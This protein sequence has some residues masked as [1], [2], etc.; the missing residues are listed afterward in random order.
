MG[1]NPHMAIFALLLGLS[2][3]QRGE[4]KP[5]EIPVRPELFRPSVR[6]VTLS[7]ITFRA[8][9]ESS[10]PGSEGYVLFPVP[11]DYSGQRV[12]SMRV[13][14]DPPAALKSWRWE[15]RPD[16]LNYLVRTDIAPT[17]GPVEIKISL[18]VLA[19][20]EGVIRTQHKDFA[21]WMEQSA[22]V[23][24]KDPEILA[25]AKTLQEPSQNRT[26]FAGRVAKWVAANKV[27]QD[28]MPGVSDAKSA[29]A[30]GGDSLGR[31]NL[32]AAVLRSVGIPARTIAMVP[33]WA[34]RIE[35]ENWL[36]E[37]W[38]EEGDWD[39]VDPNVGLKEP[40]RD[41][42]IVLAISSIADENR[43]PNDSHSFRPD[44]P[45]LTTPEVSPN[46][47]WS[48]PKTAR[49]LTSIRVVYGFPGPGGPRLLL[50]GYHLYQR[51]TEAAAHGRSV[52][53][54]DNAVKNA[55]KKGATS[56]ALLFE[57]HTQQMNQ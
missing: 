13:Q 38:S 33:T 8:R 50:A 35:G 48:E 31:A 39:M 4:Q 41:S 10:Q 20:N 26:S 16:R 47:K 51:V 36:T 57:R 15:P 7:E 5:A 37:Y 23:Q 14:A 45:K 42:I 27:R 21:D 56:L 32:C 9:V 49:R 28:Q 46:L 22:L 3:V 19:P 6:G 17:A 52:W 34:E 55:I 43:H 30:G 2:L 24:S 53:V 11:S 40:A 29:L 1:H 12:V 44:A 25:L 54:D 18:R